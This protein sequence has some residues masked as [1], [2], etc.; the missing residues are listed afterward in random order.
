MLNLTN[1]NPDA[2]MNEICSIFRE[3]FGNII[4][5]RPASALAL[6]YYK[7]IT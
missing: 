2:Y 4:E 3:E 5:H 7:K 1:T 6:D